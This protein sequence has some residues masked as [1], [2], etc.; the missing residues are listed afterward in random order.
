MKKNRPK[1]WAYL[2][3]N[4]DYNAMSALQTINIRRLIKK[5]KPKAWPT[6]C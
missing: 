6:Q 1:V 2:Q 5:D 3:H 4:V